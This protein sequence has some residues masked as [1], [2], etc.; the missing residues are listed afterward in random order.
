MDDEEKR[1]KKGV[2]LGLIW[3]KVLVCHRKYFEEEKIQSGMTHLTMTM[4]TMMMMM[5]VVAVA[6]WQ[7]YHIGNNSSVLFFSSSYARLSL[8]HS[9]FFSLASSSPHH[10]ITIYSGTGHTP[11]PTCKK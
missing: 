7:R 8:S 5:V 6:W 1:E 11:G 4:M 3:V 2:T 9:V 10:F